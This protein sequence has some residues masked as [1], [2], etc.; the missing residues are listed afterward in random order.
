[1]PYS[2]RINFVG[3][4]PVQTRGIADGEGIYCVYAPTSAMSNLIYIGQSDQIGERVNDHPKRQDWIIAAAGHPLYFSAAFTTPDIDRLLAEAAMINHYK[5]ICN[6]THKY[7]FFLPT[8]T[9]TTTGPIAILNQFFTV[10]T[11]SS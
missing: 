10:Y 7:E 5:P 1:M 8:T 6:S 3:H 4:W 11:S 9:V 2:F